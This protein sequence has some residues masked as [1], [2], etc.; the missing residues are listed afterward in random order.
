MKQVNFSRD[1]SLRS[2]LNS[3]YSNSSGRALNMF[4]GSAVVGTLRES[5]ISPEEDDIGAGFSLGT[6][7]DLWLV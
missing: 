5:P 1:T 4:R 6:R 7:E 2:S 3:N